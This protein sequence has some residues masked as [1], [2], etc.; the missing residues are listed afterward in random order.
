MAMS[1]PPWPPPSRGSWASLLGGN[2]PARNDD[3]VMEIVLEKDER[4]SFNASDEEVARALQKLG[5]DLRPGVHIETVQIC[6]MGKNVIRVTLN[7]NVDISRFCN[8]EVFEIRKGIRISQVRQSG[9]KEVVLTIRGLHPNTK[10]E[11][12]FKYLN[13]IGKLEKKK[14]IMETYKDVPL[15]GL[16]NGTRKYTIDVRQ[17]LPIGTA[18]FIDGSKVNISFPGQQKFC[19][20]CFKVDRDCPGKGLARDCEANDGLKALFSDYTLDFWRKIKYSPDKSFDATELETENNV[21]IQVGGTFTPKQARD[22]DTQV[23]DDKTPL[24]MG[25]LVSNGFQNDQIQGTSRSS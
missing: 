4:G 22:M 2:L 25:Q 5:A 23:L 14:V 12:V 15:C 17:D 6:P 3:N 8:R 7:K 11:T 10:D 1:E 24:A 9:K 18:H 21:E 16:K 19:Y 13:C 20:R